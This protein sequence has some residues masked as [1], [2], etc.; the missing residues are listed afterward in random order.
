MATPTR[1]KHW[2]MGHRAQVV[3]ETG[4][5]IRARTIDSRWAEVKVPRMTGNVAPNGESWRSIAA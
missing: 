5:G 1:E 3:F 4:D 2:R